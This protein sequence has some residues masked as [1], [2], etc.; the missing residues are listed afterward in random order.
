M[1]AGPRVAHPCRTRSSPSPC[2]L[3]AELVAT[4][5]VSE[6]SSGILGGMGNDRRGLLIGLAFV[7]LLAGVV[8]VMPR[9]GPPTA[10]E[11]EVVMIAS[12]PG[13]V[14]PRPDPGS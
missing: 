10:F 5:P 14:V 1:E 7:V 4:A 9:A 2:R 13:A 6:A 12:A 3:F 11:P 8:A